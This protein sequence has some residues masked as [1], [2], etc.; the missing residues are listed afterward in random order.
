MQNLSKSFYAVLSLVLLVSASAPFQAGAV[1]VDP[2]PATLPVSQPA[3]SQ[4]AIASPAKIGLPLY[5][6]PSANEKNW[7]TAIN[8][9]SGV[10]FII[11]NVYNGPD[12]EKKTVWT[13]M[14]NKAVAA[15][16]KVYGYVDTDYT[17]VSGATADK[18]VSRWLSFYPQISGIFFDEVSGSADKLSYYKARYAYVKNISQNLKVVIDPGTNTDEGY[19]NVSDVNGMFTGSYNSWLKHKVPTWVAKYPKER[20]ST[21]IYDVREPAMKQVVQAAKEKNFGNIFVTSASGP[22]GTL[23]SYFQAELAEIASNTNPST[24]PPVTTPA[25]TPI[26]VPAPAPQPTPIPTPVP[27]PTPTP[28]P[29]PIPQPTPIPAPVITGKAK[30]ALPLY[31]Y[32]SAGEANWQTAMN[33]AG[34]VDFIIANV[35]DGPDTV[36]KTSWTNMINKAIA[37]GVKVYGYVSTD[38]TRV[39]GDTVDKNVALWL[40]FY[41]QISGFFFDETSASADKLPYYKARYAYVK[42]INRNLKVVINPGTNTDEGYMSASDVNVIFESPYSSWLTNKVPAW[43]AN[44]PKERFYTIVYS[45]STEAAM[46]EV[47]RVAKEKNFGKIFVTSASGP[48]GA[49]PSYFQSELTEIAK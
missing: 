37:A 3:T 44:Y 42:G 43:V 41:P 31:I 6:Y 47:V 26:P 32:P 27:Q 7:Q 12:T 11:A 34:G 17:R 16:I 10:G 35:N 28:I 46:K 1:T 20:F 36:V 49:L 5:I 30:T 38:Y 18:N 15:G 14:I 33:A 13:N 25:P 23:P 8:A 2:V 29:A 9:A 19:M 24:S 39:S 40:K 45:A 21:F 22:S 4:T 48:S